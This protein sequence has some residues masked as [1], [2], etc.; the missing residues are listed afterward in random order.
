M[1]ISEK[2]CL[3]VRYYKL[4]DATLTTRL[5]LWK[6]MH[7]RTVHC[8]KRFSRTLKFCFFL[9]PFLILFWLS[10]H[11][12][13]H[14]CAYLPAHC[15]TVLGLFLALATSSALAQQ[16]PEASAYHF[17][18]GSYIQFT[19]QPAALAG[20][21]PDFEITFRSCQGNGLLAYQTGVTGA[22]WAVFLV[23]NYV[24]IQIRS[25]NST[26]GRQVSHRS[27]LDM[28]YSLLGCSVC[29]FSL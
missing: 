8:W 4:S 17:T 6:R 13:V 16:T 28:F 22:Y 27:R 11:S 21:T 18:N 19:T 24:S 20:G 1:S 5:F 29:P 9:N 15:L 7:M 2:T 26:T 14:V 3:A 12:H 23:N 10:V 25:Q